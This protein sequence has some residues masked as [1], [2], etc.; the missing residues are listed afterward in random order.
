MECK[1]KVWKMLATRFMKEIKES[2]AT[3]VR[4]RE[5]DERN[6]VSVVWLVLYSQMMRIVV[7]SDD[8][9]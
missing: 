1:I 8:E 7:L 2:K 9:P 5:G 6:E 4:E 3:G